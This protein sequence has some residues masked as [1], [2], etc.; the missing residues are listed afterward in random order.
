MNLLFFFE[1]LILLQMHDKASEKAVF[2]RF[3]AYK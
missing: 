2:I 1:S 3:E